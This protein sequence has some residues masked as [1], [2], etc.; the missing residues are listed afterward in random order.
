M[1]T[2]KEAEGRE[3]LARQL[4]SEKSRAGYSGTR[5]T[6]RIPLEKWQRPRVH[7]S[8]HQPPTKQR[9]VATKF[10]GF[11]RAG[12]HNLEHIES[13]SLCETPPVY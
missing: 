8:R 6:G 9:R 11:E 12:L 13:R 5:A 1:K 4:T 7:R 2:E 3:L 10:P